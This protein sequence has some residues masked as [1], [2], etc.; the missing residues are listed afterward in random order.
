MSRRRRYTSDPVRRIADR[1]ALLEKREQA[2]V[3]I[4]N[5]EGRKSIPRLQGEKEKSQVWI[6]G[7][8]FSSDMSRCP[9]LKRLGCKDEDHQP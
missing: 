8:S 1:P 9:I 4:P 3:N 5:Q 2:I 6:K 7:G